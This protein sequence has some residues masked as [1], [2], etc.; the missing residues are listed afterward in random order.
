MFSPTTPRGEWR[1]ARAHRVVK[2]GYDA[3]P[4]NLGRRI[5][6][7]RE[8]QRGVAAGPAIRAAACGFGRPWLVLCQWNGRTISS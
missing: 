4:P 2:L 6:G 5:A 1:V 8:F 7:K 3:K